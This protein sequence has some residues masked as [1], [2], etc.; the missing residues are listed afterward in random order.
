MEIF[1][2]KLSELAEGVFQI[3]GDILTLGKIELDFL[4]SICKNSKLKRARICTHPTNDNEIHEMLIA[5][6]KGSYVQ[7]HKHIGKS[8][9]FH[10]IRGSLDIIIFDDSGHIIKVVKLRENCAG[11]D[12]FYRMNKDFFHT[13][14]VNSEVSI[15]HETT[16]GPF[17]LTRTVFAEFAPSPSEIAESQLYMDSI[18]LKIQSY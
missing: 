9:S 7:P 6:S 5:V 14:I 13:V 4:A 17:D 15:F 2:D 12:I 8:E 1:S 3:N 10:I 11:G 16:N 18:S